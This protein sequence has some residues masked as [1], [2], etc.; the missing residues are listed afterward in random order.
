MWRGGLEEC[1]FVGSILSRGE[2]EKG[3]SNAFEESGTS[4]PWFAL[5]GVPSV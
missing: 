4:I 3:A 2:K 5:G 1:C